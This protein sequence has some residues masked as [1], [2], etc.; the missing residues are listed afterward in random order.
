M[1]TE[2]KKNIKG[3]DNEVIVTSRVDAINVNDELDTSSF[4]SSIS[5]ER[6]YKGGHDGFMK[7][8]DIENIAVG[9]I[10]YKQSKYDC[11]SCFKVQIVEILNDKE[12]IVRGM[13][14]GKKGKKE[15]KPFK[16]L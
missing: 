4:G 14:K 1:K 12:V 10:Y 6:I 2:F 11:K 13:T 8:K 5:K 3:N 7:A 9:D 16:R 15:S